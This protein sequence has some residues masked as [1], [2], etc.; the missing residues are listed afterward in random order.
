MES[1]N[2]PLGPGSPTAGLDYSPQSPSGTSQIVYPL[3]TLNTS[4]VGK[5]QHKLWMSLPACQCCLQC[6]G[7]WCLHRSTD[8]ACGQRA[9]IPFLKILELI[10]ASCDITLSHDAGMGRMGTPNGLH[11]KGSLRS[12]GGSSGGF[13]PVHS[14]AFAGPRI[15]VGKLNKDTSE[16]DVKVRS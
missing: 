4:G 12:N 16:H 11:R 6:F 7:W 15:F 3:I 1:R 9:C 14:E 13:S 8:M 5:Q 10:G 2:A